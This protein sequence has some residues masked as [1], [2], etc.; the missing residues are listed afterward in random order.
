MSKF[1]K[2]ANPRKDKKIFS[3]TASMVHKK[4]LISGPMRGGI[5]L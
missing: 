5:R 1:R 2:R 3:H 4:N